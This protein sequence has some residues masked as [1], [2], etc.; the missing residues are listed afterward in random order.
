MSPKENYM[1]DLNALKQAL[2]P[3]AKFGRDEM[4]FEAAGMQITIRP[5]LP[6]EEVAVQR[7]AASVLDDIQAQEGLSNEDQMSRAAALDYFDR[8][9]MEIVANSIVQV[10]DL[11]LR[12]VKTLPTGE[13]L[14]NGVQ[15]Q[16]PK[17]LAM[18]EIVSGW[19]RALIT[20]CFQRYGDLV[21]RIADQADKIAQTTLPDLDAEIERVETRLSRLK[22]ERETRAKGDPSVTTQQITK[23]VKAGEA[24][25]REAEMAAMK[26]EAEILARR[27]QQSEQKVVKRQPVTPPS[28]PPP[29]A[30]STTPPVY[31]ASSPS[32]VAPEATSDF[33]SSFG[34]GDDPNA[35][36]AEEN[37]IRAARAAAAAARQ[38]VEAG[39]GEE[40]DRLRKAEPAG[41]V[42]GVD[43]YRLPSENLSPRGRGGSQPVPD[44]PKSPGTANPNFKPSR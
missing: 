2:A 42:G 28:S 24:L 27:A 8:F 6:V 18:R 14:D 38:Q 43:A 22:E 39:N 17:N 34:D 20:I 30:G 44:Q 29:T 33:Q 37:R 35:L 1:L 5:L 15:V 36:A 21:Q 40:G 25:E 3:L 19:S 7:Y 23:L 10:N 9:R 32:P 16:I 41:T 12:E 11:D 26:A 13:V 4:S 31:K